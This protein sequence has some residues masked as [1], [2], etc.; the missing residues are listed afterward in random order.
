MMIRKQLASATVAW[1]VSMVPGAAMAASPEGQGATVRKGDYT[2]A[3]YYFPNYH[4]DPRNEAQH[5][6]GWTEW[7]LVRR[8]EPKFPGHEQPKVP[9]WGYES[10]SDPAKMV[11]KIDAA[12][13]HGIDV[14]I[15]DWYY[16]DDGPFIER[17]LEQGFLKAPNNSRIKFGIMW[18]N[19]DWV[20]IH[21][22]K[23]GYAPLQYPGKVTAAT[24]DRMTDH[25][26]NDY[27]K[28]PSYWKI[29]GRPYFSVYELYKL[30]EGL[31][32]TEETL[33][34][35]QR[36]REKTKAAGFPDL[37]LNAVAAGIQILP[38]EKQ[39]KNPAEMVKHLNFDSVTSY[40][41]V[42]HIGFPEFPKTP[43]AY[44]QKEAAAHWPRADKEFGVPY[45]PNVTM[46]WDPTPR[47]SQ[48]D[49]FDNKGYP[50]MATISGN[51]PAAFKESLAQCKEFL[52]RRG[53]DKI[54]TINAWN[55]WTEGSYLEPDT[56]N[57]MAYLE[58][59]RSV[60]GV[61]K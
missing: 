34:A 18:A 28:H 56:V 1:L 50:F 16:Y 8:A 29:D 43:Y 19:H 23:R 3:C 13:D 31:G 14:F 4:V 12:A 60:F 45:H 11:K 58:A 53:G 22:A 36:F 54:L 21:P 27:F 61:R 37:H 7:E 15:Y 38:G 9:L 46:G 32:G 24:F 5:G 20:D 48:T 6:P 39:L 44:F 52:D 57:R 49:S 17:G 25:V 35:L 42:H 33:K 41:W 2:V 55:E 59:V 51:T 47:T 30:I 26:I 40:V 10:E